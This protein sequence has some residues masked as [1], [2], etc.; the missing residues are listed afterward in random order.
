M[1]DP[2]QKYFI[3][4]AKPSA[5]AVVSNNPWASYNEWLTIKEA[6]DLRTLE[7]VINLAY[8]ED[9]YALYSKVHSIVF[10]AHEN[11]WER[12]RPLGVERLNVSGTAVNFIYRGQQFSLNTYQPFV[13]AEFP[14][15]IYIVDTLANIWEAKLD[16]LEL[17]SINV[18]IESLT[19]T[20]APNNNLS[21]TVK[22]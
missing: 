6:A 7:N 18:A 20:I 5:T 22:E 12:T 4:T 17:V 8:L 21:F 9:G 19:L 14:D 10:I 2:D 15:K 3:P 13:F 11:L 16:S 1:S